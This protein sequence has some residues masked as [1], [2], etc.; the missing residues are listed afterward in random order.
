V[1]AASRFRTERLE[2]IVVPGKP[3]ASVLAHRMQ[4]RDPR[5]Q[6]PPLGTRLADAE[7]IALIRRWIGTVSPQPQ[8]SHP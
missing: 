4:S 1:Q 8:E 6:M 3:E 5:I 7:G 2:H